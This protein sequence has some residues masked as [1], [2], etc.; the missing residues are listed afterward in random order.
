[1]SLTYK[2]KLQLVALALIGLAL[3]Y[4]KAALSYGIG[5]RGGNVEAGVA[6]LFFGGTLIILSILLIVTAHKQAPPDS[7]GTKERRAEVGTAIRFF[8]AL[9]VYALLVSLIGF[10]LA[11]FVAVGGMLRLFFSYSWRRAILYAGILTLA[12][13][14]IFDLALGVNLP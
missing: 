2:R 9:V 5:M 14:L 4:S 10:L 11:T 7:K 13:Y 3:V 6:P 12:C 1:M 8:G